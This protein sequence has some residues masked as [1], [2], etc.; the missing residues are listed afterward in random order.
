MPTPESIVD[1]IREHFANH[2]QRVVNVAIGPRREG[3][4]NAEVF[5]AINTN[6]SI[7][8]DDAFA[9]YGEENI[10]TVMGKVNVPHSGD[11]EEN[12]RPDIVGYGIKADGY[13]VSFVIEAKVVYSLD[14]DNGASVLGTLNDQVIRAKTFF[15]NATCMGLVYAVAVAGKGGAQPESFFVR[16]ADEMRS[17]MPDSTYAWCTNVVE[18]VPNL[19]M[20]T[21][22]MP[23]PSSTLSLGLGGRYI[24]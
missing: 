16:V 2:A 20:L 21:T 8:S 19:R 15:P 4:F 9:A 10:S 22:T 17:A 23:Y 12:R 1:F 3:W 14:Q 13:D 18:C 11:S 24:L 5:V 7:L 6:A